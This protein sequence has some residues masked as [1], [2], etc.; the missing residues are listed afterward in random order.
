MAFTKV[1]TLFIA[2]AMFLFLSVANAN[3]IRQ[4]V[5][6]DLTGVSNC[7]AN[8]QAILSATSTAGVV[9]CTSGCQFCLDGEKY[10]VPD[11]TCFEYCKTT[12]WSA[13]GICKDTIE[14]DKACMIGCINSL[15]QGSACVGCSASSNTQCCY[16]SKY[17]YNGTKYPGCQSPT[18]SK[19][20]SC[21]GNCNKYPTEAQCN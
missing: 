9:A 19:C 2:F 16:A 15:C 3:N 18:A 21:K 4:Q 5:I 1:S 14:P 10:L 11:N 12:N 8:C 6:Q 17:T 7:E 20:G 13:Q